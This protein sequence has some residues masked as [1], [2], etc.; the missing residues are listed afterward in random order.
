ME[1]F[2]A[3]KVKP[4]IGERVPLSE[5]AAA[6]KPLIHRQVKGKVVIFPEA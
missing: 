5:A 3:G 6:M 1:W 4:S 2:A